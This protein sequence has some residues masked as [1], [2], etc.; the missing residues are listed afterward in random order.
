MIAWLIANF[1]GYLAMA[2]AALAALAAIYFKGRSDKGAAVESD[3]AD[4]RIATMEAAKEVDDE[5]G[6]MD[7]DGVDTRLAQW[8]RDGSGR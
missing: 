3:R 1:G 4:E 6:N 8:M 2:G 7:A 5:V